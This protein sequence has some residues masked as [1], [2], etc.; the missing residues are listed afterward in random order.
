[1]DDFR[2]IDISEAKAMIERG[3]V[4]LVDIRDPASFAEAHI[5]DAASVDQ[6]NVQEFIQSADKQKPLICYCYHG[7]SSQSAA[8]FFKENGFNAVYSIAGGFEEYRKHYPST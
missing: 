1:M 8:Q 6:Q 5:T 7:I 4:T 2:E 3:G